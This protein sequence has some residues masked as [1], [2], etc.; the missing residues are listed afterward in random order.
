MH[1]PAWDPGA[2]A[3]CAGGADREFPGADA[4]AIDWSRDDPDHAALL[5]WVAAVAMAAWLA[6]P[7]AAGR[8][9]GGSLASIISSA[10][11]CRSMTSRSSASGRTRRY[12][13]SVERASR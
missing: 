1:D 10:A 11:R 12:A 4:V 3:W 7:R 9:C 5:G 13:L 2:V 8:H 6:L